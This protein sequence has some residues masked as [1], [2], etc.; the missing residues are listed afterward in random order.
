MRNRYNAKKMNKLMIEV[1]Q[2]PTGKQ[3]CQVQV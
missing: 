1:M 3:N 2:K